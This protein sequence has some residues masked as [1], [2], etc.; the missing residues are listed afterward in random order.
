MRKTFSKAEGRRACLEAKELLLKYLPKLLPED[1]Q[2]PPPQDKSG[3]VKLSPKARG[4]LPFQLLASDSD[5]PAW[6]EYVRSARECDHKTE[7]YP[8]VIHQKD[9]GDL[10]ITMS[11][12]DFLHFTFKRGKPIEDPDLSEIH[13]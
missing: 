6:N 2:A 11:L 4:F 7:V 10:L 3:I 13:L 12:A 5:K 8:T 1:I 9:K